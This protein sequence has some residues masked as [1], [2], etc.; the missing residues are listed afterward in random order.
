MDQIQANIEEMGN[1]MDTRMAQFVEA[2]TNV[3]HNQEE[4]RALVERP[5]VENERPDL[6]F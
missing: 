6:I 1:Q 3:T 2:I 5:R 4:L